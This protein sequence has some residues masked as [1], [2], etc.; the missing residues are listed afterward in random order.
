M[1]SD[2]FKFGINNGCKT[3]CPVFIDGYCELEDPSTFL[4]MI[5][6]DKD[7]TDGDIDNFLSLYPALYKE[8]R[9]QKLLKI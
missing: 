1:Y 7:L 9:K 3:Y 5:L 2:C 4:D 8:Y 6:N